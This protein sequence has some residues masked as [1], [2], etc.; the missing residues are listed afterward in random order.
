MGAGGGG[1]GAARPRSRLGLDT[2]CVCQADAGWSAR[3]AMQELCALL[4]SGQRAVC[5]VRP[6]SANTPLA[7]MQCWCHAVSEDM[8]VIK[9]LNL[10]TH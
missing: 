2:E 4:T 8:Q 3:P 7:L 5:A 6:T 9:L 1:G 10:V